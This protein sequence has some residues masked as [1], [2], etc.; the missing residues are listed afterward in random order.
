MNIIFG[1][2]E[3]DKQRANELKET[4][5]R[6]F[7][8]KLEE[9]NFELVDHDFLRKLGDSFATTV[10]KY[11]FNNKDW[12]VVF[13]HFPIL[14]TE[15]KTKIGIIQFSYSAYRNDHLMSPDGFAC[16][17]FPMSFSFVMKLPLDDEEYNEYCQKVEI[18]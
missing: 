13:F 17:S 2:G 16:L 14:A 5:I 4:I 18:F 11:Q 9:S 15:Y 12:D 10:P 7:R 3:A 6:F 1:F 8:E